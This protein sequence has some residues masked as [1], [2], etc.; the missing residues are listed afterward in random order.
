[1]KYY[2]PSVVIPMLRRVYPTMMDANLSGRCKLY[3][4]D[5][6]LLKSCVF[7]SRGRIKNALRE[8]DGNRSF[9]LVNIIEYENGEP[10]WR[11]PK[12]FRLPEKREA[13]IAELACLADLHGII[14]MSRNEV[15]VR[16]IDKVEDL[17][18]DV[19]LV[20]AFDRALGGKPR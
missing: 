17:N 18:I 6:E 15:Y 3:E 11:T 10:K 9:A 1:M 7:L 19:R 8:W 13:F 5:A 20:D 12:L 2:K 4:K 16:Q 14:K